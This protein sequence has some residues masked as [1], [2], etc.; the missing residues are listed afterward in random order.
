MFAV[1]ACTA[2]IATFTSTTYSLNRC[3]APV[4]VGTFAAVR[5]AIAVVADGL[6]SRVT[7]VTDCAV[8]TLWTIFAVIA[9]IVVVGDMRVTVATL[10]ML[11]AA[12]ATAM[13]MLTWSIPIIPLWY[14]TARTL[15]ASAAMLTLIA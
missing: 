9:D 8:A 11:A 10:F 7:T 4:A 2:I 12:Q 14:T 5:T 15:P 3:I 1:L 13:A 6:N